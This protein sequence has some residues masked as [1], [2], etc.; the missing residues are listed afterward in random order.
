MKNV[1]TVSFPSLGIEPFSM[2]KIA[3][4]IGSIEVRWYGIVI[5]LGIVLAFVYAWWRGKRNE[6]VS[7][8]DIIDI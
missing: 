1:T 5:T 2:N 3:F 6:G 8:E 4:S 7:S